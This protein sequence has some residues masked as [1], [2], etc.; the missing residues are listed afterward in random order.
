MKN[1]FPTEDRLTNAYFLAALNSS[2]AALLYIAFTW[3]DDY[4]SKSKMI[5]ISINF[6]LEIPLKW[7]Y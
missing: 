5:Y 1:N 3:L 2:L 6:E 4:H 7:T